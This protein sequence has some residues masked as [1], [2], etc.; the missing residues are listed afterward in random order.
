MARPLD[1]KSGPP[2]RRYVVRRE[3]RVHMEKTQTR[4]LNRWQDTRGSLFGLKLFLIVTAALLSWSAFAEVAAMTPGD[5]PK[6]SS[7]AESVPAG[8]PGP[9]ANPSDPVGGSTLSGEATASPT[10][11]PRAQISDVA[12]AVGP[13]PDALSPWG[14]FVHADVVVK[15]VIIGLALASIAT[16]TV[17]L[18]KTIQL[19]A[20]KRGARR[21]LVILLS[22]RSFLDGAGHFTGQRTAVARLLAAAEDE[23]DK[24]RGL[25]AEGIKERVAWQLERIEV[26]AGQHIGRGMGI[27]ATVGAI[28]PFVGLFG[29]VWGIMNSFI[30][31]SRAHTTNLAI[32]APGIAEALLA[33]AFGLAAAIPAVVIYNVF[34][35][36]T[37]SYRAVLSDA[38][39]A[40]LRLLSRDLER[41]ALPLNARR[42]PHAADAP[43]LS[44]VESAE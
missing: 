16:W 20:A 6:E 36:S 18:V 41:G 40:I 23:V 3:H 14:M 11:S 33:T 19:R 21:A 29:T 28:A 35:R 37:G 9:A 10:A 30:G 39:V 38:S 7:A 5:S 43:A 13:L 42:E 8:V 27:L 32:V 22:A 4:R 12:S 24:S 26:A 34:A 44:I 17:L 1:E 2:E 15:A 25:S 31:I